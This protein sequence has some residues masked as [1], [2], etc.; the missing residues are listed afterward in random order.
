V[1]EA[2]TVPLLMHW[3]QMP[4]LMLDTSGELVV[5]RNMLDACPDVLPHHSFASDDTWLTEEVSDAIET[6]SSEYCCV[7]GK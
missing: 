6:V 5:G 2:E 7:A 1:F 3:L 4:N